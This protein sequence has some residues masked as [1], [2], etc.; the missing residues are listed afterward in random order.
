MVNDKLSLEKYIELAQKE[1]KAL[2][3]VMLADNA[4]EMDTAPIALEAKMQEM[5]QVMR[6][7]AIAQKTNPA[8]EGVFSVAD[9]SEM[10]LMGYLAFLDPPKETT[11]AAINALNE[12]G[13]GVKVLT[14]DNDAVTRW[15]C[16]QVGM[17]KAT[18]AKMTKGFS[19]IR[20]LACT[21]ASVK[22]MR[23]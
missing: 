3:E 10:V 1:N 21:C 23:S 17:T 14:G 2:Y 9:E 16:E 5:L 7:I 15:I 6:V 20:A 18:V 13:V 8:V 22:I 12:Y 4:K 11:L 19:L